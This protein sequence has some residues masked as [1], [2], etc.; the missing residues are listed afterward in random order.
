MA[1][2]KTNNKQ[3]KEVN[4][5]LE[6]EK[7]VGSMEKYKTGKEEVWGWRYISVLIMRLRKTSLRG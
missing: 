1:K 2:R 6:D 7:M 3:K 5:K 4:Y